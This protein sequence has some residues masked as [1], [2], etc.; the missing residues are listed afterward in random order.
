MFEQC[1]LVWK[2]TNET[3]RIS[4]N[5]SLYFTFSSCFPPAAYG[6][7]H[8]ALRNPSQEEC[9]INTVTNALNKLQEPVSFLSGFLVF[10]WIR[11]KKKKRSPWHHAPGCNI[12]S[13]TRGQCHV[14]RT[15]VR[16]TEEGSKLTMTIDNS[17][18][19][20]LHSLD[21]N[22]E[23]TIYYLQLQ[24]HR[25]APDDRR[26]PLNPPLNSWIFIKPTISPEHTTWSLMKENI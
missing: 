19:F 9:E 14:D 2:T 8:S 10:C 6:L 11:K 7:N 22:S 20:S 3:G 26:K 12:I 15:D 18:R 13:S 1:S 23:N 21:T 5:H 24:A 16:G 17:T 4:R 25:E